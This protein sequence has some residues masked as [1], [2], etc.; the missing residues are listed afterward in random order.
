MNLLIIFGRERP[1]SILNSYD[2]KFL[3]LFRTSCMVAIATAVTW[4]TQTANFWTDFEQRVIDMAINEW[5][6]VK[7][8]RL[9]FEHLL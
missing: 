6:C 8:E 7:A 4:G 9:L 2:K 1:Y 5:A 3:K